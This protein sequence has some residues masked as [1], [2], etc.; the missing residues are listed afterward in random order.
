M[1]QRNVRK[2]ALKDQ[3][4]Q[5]S[6]AASSRQKKDGTRTRVLLCKFND[7]GGNNIRATRSASGTL[8]LPGFDPLRGFWFSPR[9][10]LKVFAYASR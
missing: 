10:G 4:C 1:P 3:S 5:V 6:D 7:D 9:C 8:G 2:A